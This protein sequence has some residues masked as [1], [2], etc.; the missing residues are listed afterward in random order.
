[1]TSQA[2]AVANEPV[3]PELP[4]WLRRAIVLVVVVTT[5]ISALGTAFLPY[6][7]VEH[8]VWLLLT[9]SDVR[10][11]VLVAPQMDCHVIALVAV[12]RRILAMFGTYGMGVLYGRALIKLAT[13]KLPRIARLIAWFEGLFVPYRGAWVLLWPAY[14]TAALAGITRM[15]L[16]K[17]VPCMVVGQIGFVVTTFYL[18]GAMSAWTDQ[19]MVWLR[20]RVWETTAVCVTLVSI[21]QLVSFIRRRRAADRLRVVTAAEPGG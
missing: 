20:G 3:D 8:P 18:G 11:I 17:F 10:N 13:R 6:L 12:P 1:M 15:P 5:A 19:L 2:D 4:P 7:L 21:Q 14:A 9:S 16:R